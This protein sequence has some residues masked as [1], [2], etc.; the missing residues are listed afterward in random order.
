[1]TKYLSLKWINDCIRSI[2]ISGGLLFLT[3][4]LSACQPGGGN[5]APVFSVVRD[6]NSDRLGQYLAEGGNPNIKDSNGDYLLYV[7][8]GAKGGPEVVD[9]LLLGG[10]NPNLISR[11]GRTALHTAAGWCNTE[12]V[13]LLLDAGA[14]T[15]IK[16]SD[17]KLAIDV[18]CT[19]PQSRRELVLAL[20]LQAR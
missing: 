7:A 10:A 9:L 8:S 3:L 17:N 1:M 20:F 13:G 5:D 15:D 4:L 19:Q 11:Q 2:V 6:N 14:R 12:I 18:V 16:N